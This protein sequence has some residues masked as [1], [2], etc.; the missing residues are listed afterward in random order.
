[1]TLTDPSTNEPNQPHAQFASMTAC[2][3]CH[4]QDKQVASLKAPGTCI[5]CHPKDFQLKPA[6]HLE[7]DFFPAGHGELGKEAAEKV[8]EATAES[9]EDETQSAGGLVEVSAEDTHGGELGESLPPV[10]S[11]NECY[12]CHA[13]KFCND[14]HGAPMPHPANFKKSHGSY[15]K[16]NPQ[17]CANCHGDADRF[18]DEC[19][20][21]TSLDRKYDTSQSWFDQHPE[22]V[23]SLGAGSC[24]DCHD[25]TYCARCHVKGTTQ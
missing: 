18:C 6:S 7:D 25:P 2:F 8:A 4:T 17:A 10:D 22:A 16:K 20:H 9:S 3:R 11:I 13:E 12:T 5:T 24:L 19:H 1:L 15:G 21:K 14:C 23:R